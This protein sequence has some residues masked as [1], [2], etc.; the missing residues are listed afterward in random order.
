MSFFVI[1]F[2]NFWTKKSLMS[3][4]LKPQFW[5]DVTVNLMVFRFFGK[6]HRRSKSGPFLSRNWVHFGVQNRSKID[7]KFIPE[8][9]EFGIRFFMF[10]WTLCYIIFC[11]IDISRY[12]K[13]VQKHCVF[14][15]FLNINLIQLNVNKAQSDVKRALKNHR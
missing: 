3:D 13:N 7:E 12:T 10:F 8:I 6:S 15:H 1:D 14:L 11:F 9:D 5:R 2:Y 4:S